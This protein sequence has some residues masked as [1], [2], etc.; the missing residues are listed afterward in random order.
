MGWEKGVVLKFYGDN[1]N[2]GEKDRLHRT[3]SL[4]S[5]FTGSPAATFNKSG[6]V[7]KGEKPRIPPMEYKTKGKSLF[8][9][10]GPDGTCTVQYPC[11]SRLSLYLFD[12]FNSTCKI[13]YL[14]THNV[15]YFL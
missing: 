1:R 2:K 13:V 8:V 3:G 10:T 15:R 5:G 9:C 12:Y 6:P 11:I 14:H 4:T 7:W